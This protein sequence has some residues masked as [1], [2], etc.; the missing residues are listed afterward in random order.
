MRGDEYPIDDFSLK[1]DDL[2]TSTGELTDPGE[3]EVRERS[4]CR[5]YLCRSLSPFGVI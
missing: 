5:S 1:F 3:Q 2:L 4:F